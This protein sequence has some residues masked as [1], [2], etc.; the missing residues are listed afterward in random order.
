MPTRTRCHG[1]HSD[2]DFGSGVDK[3]PT[4]GEQYPFGHIKQQWHTNDKLT[5]ENIALREQ[6]ACIRSESDN[7]RLSTLSDKIDALSAENNQLKSA[8]PTYTDVA[9]ATKSVLVGDG[10]I[11]GLSNIRTVGGKSVDMKKTNGTSISV[12]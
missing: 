9:Q 10:S 1:W 7:R 5:N 4:A 3:P 2:D 8:K 12:Q 11:S 6:I